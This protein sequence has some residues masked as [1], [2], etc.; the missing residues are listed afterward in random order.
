MGKNLV[1]IFWGSICSY[2]LNV[3]VISYR[4][5]NNLFEKN[6]AP[7]LHLS[8]VEITI[9]KVCTPTTTHAQINIH[10]C[11]CNI[12]W[13]PPLTDRLWRSGKET[14]GT[15]GADRHVDCRWRRWHLAGSHHWITAEARSSRVPQSHLFLSYCR[16]QRGQLQPSIL[17]MNVLLW[18]DKM[19]NIPIGFIPLGSSNSLSPS[20]HLLS[21]NKVK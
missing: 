2:V 14:D 9:V 8:G 21:D 17:L 12:C 1:M 3:R 19:S 16:T 5:A 7:I 15:H 6:V 20:L 18:Q 4:K 13:S 10:I 11:L